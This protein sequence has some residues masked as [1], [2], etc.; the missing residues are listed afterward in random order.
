[1]RHYDG[2]MKWDRIERSLRSRGYCNAFS[3]TYDGNVPSDFIWTGKE[4]GWQ[5][6]RMLK[7][8]CEKNDIKDYVI[9]RN[10]SY[11][12]DLHGNRVYELWTKLTPHTPTGE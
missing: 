2:S 11:L 3:L 6:R 10:E 12:R 1:M 7:A 4:S 5:F 8:Y 9:V